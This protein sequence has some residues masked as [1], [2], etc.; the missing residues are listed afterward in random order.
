MSSS[1]HDLSKLKIRRDEPSPATRRAMKTAAWLAGLAV[2]FVVVVLMVLRGGGTEVTVAT[3][4]V[5]GGE[6]GGSLG[7]TANGYV[8]ARTKAS[9]SSRI[10]GRLAYL[11][12][13]EGSVVTR[14]EIIA[15]LENDD[16]KAIVV[17]TEAEVLRAEAALS[18][19]PLVRADRA[20][21]LP[22]SFAQERLW[23]L[24]QLE[25]GSAAYNVPQVNEIRQLARTG[26][27]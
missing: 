13:E 11:G 1:T 24:D 15:S 2:V 22:L 14:G 19:P 5:V 18:L 26:F 6:S 12:V 21:D 17:Q 4:Q 20:E 16:Y 25:P 3:A 9:V 23:F 27:R 10:S 7:I 8:V